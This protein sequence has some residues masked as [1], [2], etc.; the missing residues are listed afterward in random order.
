MFLNRHGR[1]FILLAGLGLAATSG[2]G[3]A[4]AADS[5]YF[6]RW[7]VSDEKPVFT[8]RGRLY[9]TID[10]APCGK[11]FCGVSVDDSGNC[12][13]TLFRF[14]TIHAN[15]EELTG[16]GRWGTE[17]KK[18]VIDFVRSD[19]EPPFLMLGLGA[20]D[21][22]FTGREGSMPTFQANYKN[23]GA[24]SCSAEALTN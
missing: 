8:T 22:D 11:D 20:D 12:G 13:A 2:G 10:V 24:A 23:A 17:K 16:H 21:F 6:G 14:L 5:L 18:L 15:N 9:K 1:I 7:T 3:V 19:S 4:R